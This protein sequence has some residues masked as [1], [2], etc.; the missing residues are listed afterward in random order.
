MIDVFQV[1][2]AMALTSTC[3]RRKEGGVV[4]SKDGQRVVTV[5]RSY[6]P[7]NS[8]GCRHEDVRQCPVYV[9]ALG[10]LV[11][12]GTEKLR[13]TQVYVVS[14]K[15]P[16]DRYDSELAKLFQQLGVQ[17]S[18]DARIGATS[19]KSS[20]C[21]CHES[22]VPDSCD[23]GNVVDSLNEANDD[24]HKRPYNK[25][26]HTYGTRECKRCGKQFVATHPRQLYCNQW[27]IGV[28]PVC[29]KVFQYRCE[30]GQPP[31]TCGDEKCVSEVRSRNL[32]PKKYTQK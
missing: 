29:K 4:V 20:K 7:V 10:D 13:D 26:D 14:E 12:Q 28:C 27:K 11:V 15:Y 21:V 16:W 18:C 6:C 24:T 2:N 25:S 3:L 32:V 30:S 31:V 22:V 23:K 1:A 19:S 17:Y 9:S 8:K 5:C